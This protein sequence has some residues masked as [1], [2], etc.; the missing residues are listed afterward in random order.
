MVTVYFCIISAG[1]GRK[2]KRVSDVAALGMAPTA[3]PGYPQASSFDSSFNSPM[4]QGGPQAFDGN[5]FDQPTYGFNAP[6][7]NTGKTQ[8][9]MHIW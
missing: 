9:I 2:V 1:L 6:M 4:S 3:G 8:M 7:Q 5:G